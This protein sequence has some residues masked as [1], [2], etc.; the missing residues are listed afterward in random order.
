M[1]VQRAVK[2]EKESRTPAQQ[3]IGS[4]VLYEIYRLRGQAKQKRV[5]EG[6]TLVKIDAKKRAYVDVRAEVT[7]ALEKKMTT[8][9]A[10]IVS[11]SREYR[12]ILAWVPLLKLE[13]L[14][15]DRRVVAIDMAAQART[16]R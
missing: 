3:K 12:S 9:G 2:S 4:Q 8:L 7:P 5:P 16:N 1:A 15:A 11:T 6:P 14:A 13:T 10:T